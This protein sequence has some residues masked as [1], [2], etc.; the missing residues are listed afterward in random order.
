M[1]LPGPL[2]VVGSVARTHGL[3]GDVIVDLVTNRTERVAPGA[4]LETDGGRTLRVVSSAPHGG[5][6]RVHFDGVDNIDAA[7][8][9]RGAVLRAEPLED[10]GELWVHQ[11][12]GAEVVDSTGTVRGTVTGVQANPASDLLVLDTGALVP[13]RFVVDLVPGVRVSVDVPD[14]L[15][16]LA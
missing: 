9:L 12:V 8:A 10:A 5:R 2:L 6:W 4:E 14:G 1:P 15:F 7:T 13:L 16:D 11:L 3:A